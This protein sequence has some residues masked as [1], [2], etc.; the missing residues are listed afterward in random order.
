MQC[1]NFDDGQR[2]RAAAT[3]LFP[4]TDI[5]HPKGLEHKSIHGLLSEQARKIEMALGY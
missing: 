2:G 4:A 5:A 3:A 1:L